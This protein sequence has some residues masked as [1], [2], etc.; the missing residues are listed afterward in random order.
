M[1]IPLTGKDVTAITITTG[2]SNAWRI[3]IKCASG[4]LAYRDNGAAYTDGIEVDPAEAIILNV[5]DIGGTEPL[6]F[7]YGDTVAFTLDGSGYTIQLDESI[8]T[9]IDYY[10]DDN[11]VP[12][13]DVG[14]TTFI[15]IGGITDESIGATENIDDDKEFELSEGIGITEAIVDE[16]EFETSETINLSEN[17]DMDNEQETDEHV[18]IVENITFY[19]GEAD[20]WT[21]TSPTSNDNW[22]KNKDGDIL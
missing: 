14:L 2:G 7:S 11:A 12:F 4:V 6:D 1:P 22:A 21:K 13:T 10:L 16:Q 17:F 5:S 9:D 19:Q 3:N 20:Q 18:G 15:G 8:L